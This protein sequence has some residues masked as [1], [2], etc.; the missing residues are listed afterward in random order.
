[1]IPKYAILSCDSNKEYLDFWEPVSKLWKLKIGIT[2]VLVYVSD[3]DIQL[4]CEYGEV[5]RVSPVPGMSIVTQSQLA[6]YWYPINKPNDVCIISDIDMLPLSRY[7][8][9]D[10]LKDM[11]ENSWIHLNDCFDG[12]HMS[13]CYHVAKG[14]LL[15]DVWQIHSD[16]SIFISD[17]ISRFGKKPDGAVEWWCDELW[18]TSMIHKYNNKSIFNFL[19]RD[20]GQ[21][22]HRIDR[23][24]FVFDESLLANDFYYD[25]HCPRPYAAY[26]NVIDS[27]VNISL[28][29]Y[30][31][32]CIQ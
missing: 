8:F 19:K 4:S 10:M 32:L 18:A 9:L 12:R 23:P 25:A 16:W 5:V 11:D 29:K 6:R 31:G 30:V 24:E 13:T 2:P 15:S 3:V 14:S 26:K 22:G 28:I 17:V 7:Y 21:N 20:L 1:M 27:I